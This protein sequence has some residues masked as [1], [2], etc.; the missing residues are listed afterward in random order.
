MSDNTGH[1]D[2]YQPNDLDAIERV[3]LQVCP[4]CDGGLPM[5][6]THP[7]SDYRPVMQSLVAEVRS[8]RS[9]LVEADNAR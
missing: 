8:L 5:A 9:Q 1:D 4:S 3:F 2:A 7:E 6:C